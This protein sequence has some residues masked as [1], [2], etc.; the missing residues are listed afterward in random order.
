MSDAKWAEEALSF[1]TEYA[2]QVAAGE[3]A[4]PYRFFTHDQDAA[5]TLFRHHFPDLHVARLP[6]LGAAQRYV[7]DRSWSIIVSR[8]EPYIEAARL[9]TLLR[10]DVLGAADFCLVPRV[11]WACIE[12]ARHREGCYRTAAGVTPR[13]DARVRI[14]EKD[15]ER[16][17]VAT[18]PLAA[19]EVVLRERVPAAVSYDDDPDVCWHCAKPL[20]N[21]LDFVKRPMPDCCRRPFCGETCLSA[22]SAAHA[23]ECSNECQRDFKRRLARRALQ[24]G[25]LT[26]LKTHADRLCASD[27]D[28]SDKLQ[29]AVCAV[30]VNAIALGQTGCGIAPTAAMFN[31]SCLENATHYAVW[32]AGGEPWLVFRA[33]APILA[34]E[35]V[36][37]CYLGEAMLA[38][39]KRNDFL[40]QHKC[41]ECRCARC[42][43]N[44]ACCLPAPA[45]R[46]AALD[47]LA[48]ARAALEA[49]M[50]LHPGRSSVAVGVQAEA[51]ADMLLHVAHAQPEAVELYQR[52][53]EHFATCRGTFDTP[54]FR[55][56]VEKAARLTAYTDD[57]PARL[58]RTVVFEIKTWEVRT[59]TYL[60][61]QLAPRVV[62]AAESAATDWE[63]A[64]TLPLAY[65]VLALIVACRLPDQDAVEL[66][67]AEALQTALQDDVQ[68]VDVRVVSAAT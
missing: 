49:S 9:L 1:A 68:S 48:T 41:F 60:L 62:D 45:T 16:R 40:R 2:A 24:R 65:G 55:R 52:A 25:V 44:D 35:E 15:G 32:D 59:S 56:V 53:A 8:L 42:V 63:P 61:T 30:R 21:V 12:L 26:G 54:H 3:P 39:E 14:E 50:L 29:E 34:G 46:D 64:A 57:S 38:D 4:A 11:Q 23:A 58:R 20:D 27:D 7:S 22:H 36:T 17:V 5:Y 19:G 18:R 6:R 10:R 37:I 28:A 13:E 67:L 51:L 31:H 43:R 47:A 33:V 66:E